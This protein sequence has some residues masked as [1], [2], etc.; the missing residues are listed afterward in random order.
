MAGHSAAVV[1]LFV[2]RSRLGL[3]AVDVSSPPAN[4]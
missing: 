1:V 4:P 2:E 3:V